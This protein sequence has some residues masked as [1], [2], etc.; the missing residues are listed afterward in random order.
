MIVERREQFCAINWAASINVLK[1]LIFTF[2]FCFCSCSFR[3][4]SASSSCCCFCLT[5]PR[6]GIFVIFFLFRWNFEVWKNETKVYSALFF[7][8]LLLL[9]LLLS[10]FFLFTF[11]F[12]KKTNKQTHK[13]NNCNNKKIKKIE[14]KTKIFWSDECVC[15]C[16]FC[17]CRSLSNSRAL[18]STS[19][20][21]RSISNFSFSS[22]SRFISLFRFSCSKYFLWSSMKC[23]WASWYL[24]WIFEQKK[25]HSSIHLKSEKKFHVKEKMTIDTKSASSF[26][27]FSNSCCSCNNFC[28]ASERGDVDRFCCCVDVCEIVNEDVECCN[29]SEEVECLDGDEGECG[30]A[31][32]VFKKTLRMKSVLN[33]W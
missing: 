4:F 17:S 32:E 16:T 31:E 3:L 15:E 5:F 23:F 7:K 27:F 11:Q 20:C 21:L 12:L 30:R 14:E 19:C 13:I 8:F 6:N 24:R 2:K 33:W 1:K 18:L 26:F 25:F 22:R 10:F 9:Q 28:L 29:R